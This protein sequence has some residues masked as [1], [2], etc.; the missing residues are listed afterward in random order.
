MNGRLL[1]LFVLVTATVAAAEPMVRDRPGRGEIGAA[2]A[3][4]PPA[5]PPESGGYVCDVQIIGSQSGDGLRG[6]QVYLTS[7]RSC[8]GSGETFAAWISPPGQPGYSEAQVTAIQRDLLVAAREGW[9]VYVDRQAGTA[10][11]R[12]LTIRVN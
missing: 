1:I 9:R 8:A 3:D 11:I 6:V 10:V 7:G 4:L 12:K 5:P 2:V